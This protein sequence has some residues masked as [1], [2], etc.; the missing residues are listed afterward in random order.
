[1]EKQNFLVRKHLPQVEE[2]SER[3]RWN[4]LS[5]RDAEQI[6]ESL[7]HL[8]NGLPKE[9]ELA[10]RFDLLCLKLQLAV[11]KGSGDFIGLRDKVRDILGNLEEKQ[12]IPMVKQQLPLI[13]EVQEESWWSDVTPSMIESARVRLRELV[14]FI[15][16]NQQTIV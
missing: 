5:D 3:D 7:A 2:F 16:R 15:D 11:L 8:P 13:Q 6:A 4:S 1:M 12:T 14:K 10:K 9:D